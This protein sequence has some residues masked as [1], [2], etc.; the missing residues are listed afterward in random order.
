[1]KRLG[2][3]TIA[4]PEEFAEIPQHEVNHAV[5]GEPV[6]VFLWRHCRD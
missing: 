2:D 5:R 4:E 1:M 6:R 3:F